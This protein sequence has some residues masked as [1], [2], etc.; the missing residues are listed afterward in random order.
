MSIGRV[1]AAASGRRA[2]C[3]TDKQT[4]GEEKQEPTLVQKYLAFVYPDSTHEARNDKERRE[5][6]SYGG[7]GKK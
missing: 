2:V 3:E 1:C 6:E 5:R 7:R 4:E